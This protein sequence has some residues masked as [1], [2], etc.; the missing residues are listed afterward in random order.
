MEN[1]FLMMS[2]V[3]VVENETARF[4]PGQVMIETSKGL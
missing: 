2:P 4:V 1:M 3:G